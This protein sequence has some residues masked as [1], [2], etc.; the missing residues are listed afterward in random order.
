EAHRTLMRLFALPGQRSRALAQYEDL[1][2]LLRDEL[3]VA[4]M[5]E[6]RRLHDSI[7]AEA[8]E[9]NVAT[10]REPEPIGPLIPLVGRGPAFGLLREG[11]Q[12]ALAGKVHFTLVTGEA[13]VG[14]TRLVKSFLDATT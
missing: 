6:T 7:L 1:T 11:W 9:E 3:A 2:S 4:P 8:L 5:E 13:G 14:K 10:A 12:K